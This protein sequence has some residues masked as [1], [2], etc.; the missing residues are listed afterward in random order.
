MACTALHQLRFTGIRWLVRMCLT[1]LSLHAGMCLL[2]QCRGLAANHSE[3]HSF[4]A[5]AHPVRYISSSIPLM[6]CMWH[7]SDCVRIL[8]GD[9]WEDVFLLSGDDLKVHMYRE[10]QEA[11][12]HLLFVYDKSA[13]SWGS[14]FSWHICTVEFR[15][16]A[17]QQ[18][19]SRASGLAQ[20]CDL[21][22]CEGGGRSADECC[23]LPEWLPQMCCSDPHIMQ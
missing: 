1:N 4:P 18:V 10:T 9:H 15:G 11:E 5:Y 16:R 22:G 19:V 7:I 3:L 17:I 6:L 21:H 12:V 14:V 20:Q 13:S 8:A 23:G 2:Y